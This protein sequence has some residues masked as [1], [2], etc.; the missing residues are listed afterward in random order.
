MSKAIW[1]AIAVALGLMQIGLVVAKIAGTISWSWWWTLTP[2]WLPIV[3]V[4]ALA[5]LAVGLI[6]NAS[7]NGRNPFQ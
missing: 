6:G 2:L 5:V 7:A 4:I 3:G 1:I